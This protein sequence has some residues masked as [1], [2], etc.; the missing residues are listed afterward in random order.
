MALVYYT[1]D[2][3]R[4]DWLYSAGAPDS[5]WRKQEF[6]AKQGAD[7]EIYEKQSEEKP[8]DLFLSKS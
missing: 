1:P 7:Q 5:Y 8:G 2:T 6:F 4:L 3:H